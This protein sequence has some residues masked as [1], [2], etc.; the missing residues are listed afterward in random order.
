MKFRT[1]D[2]VRCRKL[3][4]LSSAH[5]SDTKFSVASESTI[6]SCF[7]LNFAVRIQVSFLYDIITFI[8]KYK[9]KINNN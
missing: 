2:V 8:V 9:R 3:S 6:T 7:P 4:M 5:I 1:A